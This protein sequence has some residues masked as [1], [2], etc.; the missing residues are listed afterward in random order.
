MCGIWYYV[1]R[2]FAILA[3]ESPMK[4]V[5]QLQWKVVWSWKQAILELPTNSKQDCLFVTI[6][7]YHPITFGIISTNCI[8]HFSNLYTSAAALRSEKWLFNSIKTRNNLIIPNNLDTRKNRTVD[9]YMLFL[10]FELFSS[11][12]DF[13]LTTTRTTWT[14]GTTHGPKTD[15]D[16]CNKAQRCWGLEL[17]F[18]IRH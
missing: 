17:F 4:G 15:S 12:Q 16:R 2:T 11:Q 9:R 7:R 6:F 3:A 8:M 10:L 5:K 18:L 13:V 1:S 14:T